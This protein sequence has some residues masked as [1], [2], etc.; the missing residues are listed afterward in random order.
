MLR[1]L[2]AYVLLCSLVYLCQSPQFSFVAVQDL[3]RIGR[4]HL[5]LCLSGLISLGCK[6]R[7]TI[8]G[9]WKGLDSN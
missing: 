2:G 3:D 1:G 8:P 7:N 9:T 6:P 4:I 5:D